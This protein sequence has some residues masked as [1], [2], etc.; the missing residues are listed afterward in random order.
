MDVQGGLAPRADRLRLPAPDPAQGRAPTRTGTR[1][2][3]L[4]LTGS[5]AMNSAHENGVRCVPTHRH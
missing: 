2:R 1:L 4:D 5:S 3:T